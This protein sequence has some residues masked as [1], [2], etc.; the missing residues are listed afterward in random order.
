MPQTKVGINT[1]MGYE[2]KN[3]K[4]NKSR[5]KMNEKGLVQSET[6]SRKFPRGELNDY[7]R[8]LYKKGLY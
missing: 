2:R 1:N 7:D 6:V 4:R 5:P 8:M 3:I